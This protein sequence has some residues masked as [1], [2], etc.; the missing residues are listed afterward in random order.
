ME[1][2]GV[3]KGYIVTPDREEGLV[4]IGGGR[5]ISSFWIV[6]ICNYFFE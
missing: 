6:F 2:F 5:G 4:V 3:D 1:K